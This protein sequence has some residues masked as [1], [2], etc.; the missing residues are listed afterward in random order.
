VLSECGTAILAL[1]LARY[2]AAD[3]FI[4]WYREQ[5]ARIDADEL[6]IPAHLVY[7]DEQLDLPSQPGAAVAV[8][9]RNV[10][11]LSATVRELDAR[12]A[13]TLPVA[14]EVRNRASQ[15]GENMLTR[16]LALEWARSDVTVINAGAPTFVETEQGQQT[17]ADPA[18]RRYW[19]DR[20]PMSDRLRTP[21]STARSD[22][23]R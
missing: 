12:G 19:S 8:T 21:R 7:E 18:L 6:S 3:R 17:L 20:I 22:Y 11:S 9:A 23:T 13:R 14:L 10:A 5:I 2:P 15:A 16:V 4:C 1:M